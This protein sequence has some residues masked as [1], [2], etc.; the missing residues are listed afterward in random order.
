[1]PSF[2][3]YRLDGLVNALHWPFVDHKDAILSIKDLG[4]DRKALTR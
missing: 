4:K 2:A 3:D 1:M